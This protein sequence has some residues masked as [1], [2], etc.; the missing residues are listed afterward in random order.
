MTKSRQASCST[1]IA[2]K[3]CTIGACS[4]SEKTITIGALTINQVIVFENI[5]KRGLNNN[6]NN[7]NNN[8]NH[9]HNHNNNTIN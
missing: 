8:H 6:N 9:N 3:T 2:K 4:N 7:H 5:Y 1:V